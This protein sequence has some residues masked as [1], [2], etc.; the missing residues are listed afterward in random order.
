VLNRW[1]G[2]MI[3]IDL[4]GA[5]VPCDAARLFLFL[6]GSGARPGDGRKDRDRGSVECSD[7]NGDS[8]SHV[9]RRIRRMKHNI[10]TILDI[11]NPVLRNG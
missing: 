5:A 3:A 4:A 11:G 8:A 9:L 7:K 2:V 6:A 1:C 10:S